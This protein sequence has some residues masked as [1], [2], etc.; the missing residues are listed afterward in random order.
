MFLGR[1]ITYFFYIYK[2]NCTICKL[3][4]MMIFNI[5]LSQLKHKALKKQ[6][7]E[8]AL[9]FTQMYCLDPSED[10]ISI[11]ATKSDHKVPKETRK[12]SLLLQ[13]KNIKKVAIASLAKPF[14]VIIVILH[15]VS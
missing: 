11:F 2:K 1:N 6:A 10:F 9:S 14:C 13:R 7:W 8:E 5:K 12:I 15:K 3:I 4:C